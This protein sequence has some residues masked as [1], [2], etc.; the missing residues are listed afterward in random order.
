VE[1]R[2]THFLIAIATCHA[3]NP[4]QSTLVEFLVSFPLIILNRET[5]AAK[6][7]DV[8]IRTLIKPENAFSAENI[9]WQ[10]II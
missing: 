9:G 4:D 7:E 3:P 5:L 8:A 1:G 6:V 2:Q 10:L